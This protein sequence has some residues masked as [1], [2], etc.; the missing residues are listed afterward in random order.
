MLLVLDDLQMDKGCAVTKREWIQIRDWGRPGKRVG[1][2]PRDVAEHFGLDYSPL[3]R[4]PQGTV[5]IRD[6]QSEKIRA[7][8][9]FQPGEELL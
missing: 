2:I 6:D 8:K 9:E 7:H 1:W 5:W 4:T 3:D